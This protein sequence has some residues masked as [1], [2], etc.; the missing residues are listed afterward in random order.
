[1]K[2][3]DRRLGLICQLAKSVLIYIYALGVHSNAISGDCL[4]SFGKHLALQAGPRPQL[5]M[6]DAFTTCGTYE[7]FDVS[8][9]VDGRISQLV[10]ELDRFGDISPAVACRHDVENGAAG[11]RDLRRVTSQDKAFA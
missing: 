10:Q 5:C 2:V 7:K 11:D 3:C 1:M 9:G 4:E 8:G 6:A